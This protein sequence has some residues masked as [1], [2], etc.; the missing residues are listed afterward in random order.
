MPGR[1]APLLSWCWARSRE[2]RASESQK[3]LNW[4]WQ[5][6]DAVRLFEAGKEVATVPVWKGKTRKPAGGAGRHRRH[7]AQGRRRTLKTVIERTDPLVAPLA[8]GQ[9]VGTLK[10]STA[11]GTGGR[12]SA[13]G[14]GAGGTGRHPGP[15]LGRH[16]AVDQVHRPRATRRWRPTW[17]I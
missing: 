7:R 8:A 15:R 3:L 11:G 14:A 12:G 4:G 5:A 9:R 1:Q 17:P 6:W 10:V 16:P 13:D 2:A